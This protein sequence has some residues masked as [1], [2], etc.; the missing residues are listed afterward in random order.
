MMTELQSISAWISFATLLV[1]LFGFMALLRQNKRS[2]NIEEGRFLLD[3]ERSFSD[4]EKIQN[5]YHRLSIDDLSENESTDAYI[6]LS[7]FENFYSLIERKLIKYSE[8]D[9]LFG[10]RFL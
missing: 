5:I 10:Y 1:A 4:N 2:K 3:L 9:K 6:Y 8:I 7:F